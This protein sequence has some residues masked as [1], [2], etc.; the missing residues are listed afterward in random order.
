M[1][2]GGEGWGLPIGLYEFL[3]GKEIFSLMRRMK[4]VYGD[5]SIFQSKFHVNIKLQRC[6]PLPPASPLPSF[7]WEQFIQ[8]SENVQ[9]LA[10]R[11]VLSILAF[12][13]FT[14]TNTW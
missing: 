2:F 6:F 5:M 7:S 9:C 12:D 4:V 13:N 10:V 8:E 1:D 3:P 11:I 14:L